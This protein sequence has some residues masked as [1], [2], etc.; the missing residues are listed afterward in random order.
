MRPASTSDLAARRE[1]SAAQ[2]EAA[3]V[4]VGVAYRQYE[5][6]TQ[7]LTERVGKDLFWQTEIAINLHLVRAGLTGFLKRPSQITGHLVSLREVVEHHHQRLPVE[8]PHA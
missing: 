2:L 8:A 7:A 4:A 6:A 3:I 5:R 1:E